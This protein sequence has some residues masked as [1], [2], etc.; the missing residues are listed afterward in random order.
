M[1]G[2]RALPASDSGEGSSGS[3]LG[4]PLPEAGAAAPPHWRRDGAF[5]LHHY[6]VQ[7]GA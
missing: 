3:Q 4:S 5:M 7:W 1:P 2:V 6:K